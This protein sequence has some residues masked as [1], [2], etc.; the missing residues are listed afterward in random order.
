MALFE[1]ERQRTGDAM[2]SP[3]GAGGRA[4]VAAGSGGAPAPEPTEPAVK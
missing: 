4:A 1:A 3:V 2:A